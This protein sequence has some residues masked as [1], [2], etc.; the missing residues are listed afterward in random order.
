VFDPGV[1]EFTPANAP[2]NAIDNFLAGDTILVAG[3]AYTRESYTGGVL[4]LDGAGGPVK[5][6]LPSINPGDLQLSVIGGNTLVETSETPCFCRGT[7]IRTPSGDVPVEAL[8]VGDCILTLSGKAKPIVWIGTGRVL[9]TTGRRCAAT[10]VIIRRNALADNVPSRDLRITKGHSMYLDGVLIPVEFL[11]NYRSI[12]WDDRAQVVEFYHIELDA[13]DVLLADGAPAETYRDDG[14]RFLFQNANTGWGEPP[15][16]PCAPVLTGGPIVDAVWRR[17]LDRAG[18]RPEMPLTDDPD[19]YLL[20]DGE[21]V[22]ASR[23]PGGCYTF[24]LPGPSSNVRLVSRAA[25]PAELGLVRDPRRLGVAVRQIRLWQGERLLLLEAADPSLTEGFHEFEPA[26]GL[27]WTDGNALLP[28]TFLAGV[29]GPWE[30]EVL[31]GGATYYPLPMDVAECS[32][33]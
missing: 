12:L 32:A 22:D 28:A 27:R 14:N 4:K 6:D 31:T 1:L 26:D 15:K 3:F 30:L 21:R 9:V 23:Y 11:V 18:P 19:L 29:D 7:L 20:V 17:L 2:T 8:S 13:H 25:S 5:I 16:P 33:A 10:P 24:W